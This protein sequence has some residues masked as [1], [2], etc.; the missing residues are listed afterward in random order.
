MPSFPG[1]L[2]ALNESITGGTASLTTHKDH[3]NA[4]ADEVNAIEA[5]LGTNPSLA[6]ADV[7]TL[8][9]ALMNRWVPLLDGHV[10]LSAAGTGTYPAHAAVT[11]D[12][13]IGAVSPAGYNVRFM[14]LDPAD[15]AITGFTVQY[16]VVLGI[17]QNAVNDAA[18]STVVAGLYPYVGAGATTTWL[19]TLGT[20][21]AGS[22]TASQ[23]GSTRVASYEGRIVSS[24]FTAPAATTYALALVIG[25]ATTA[26][27]T[28]YSLR[29]DYRY[30]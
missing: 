18:T 19:A 14:Y 9:L 27:S 15:L 30:T 2:S 22:T 25:T 29:L 12:Q 8:N 1:A 6:A 24:P 16:R 11:E 13:A 10:N 21:V 4:L 20:V 3:H 23:A 7:G 17:S 26:G 5:E 28:R